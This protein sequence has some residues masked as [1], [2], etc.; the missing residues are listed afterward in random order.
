[1]S[2]K[3]NYATTNRL[4]LALG[5]PLRDAAGLDAY[6]A[7]ICDPASTNYRAYLTPEQFTERFGPTTNDYQKSLISPS[8]KTLPVILKH[9]DVCVS[10]SRAG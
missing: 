3:G 4:N 7:Q 1:M 8:S 6:L 9:D 2:A 5:L 10:H